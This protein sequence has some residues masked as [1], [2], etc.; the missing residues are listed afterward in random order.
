MRWLRGSHEDLT[1]RAFA[2]LYP[3]EVAG[4]VLVDGSHTIQMVL[5]GVSSRGYWQPHVVRAGAM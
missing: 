1:A 3:N 4:V 2:V 5:T